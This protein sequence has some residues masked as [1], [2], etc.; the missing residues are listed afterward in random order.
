MLVL[1][2]KNVYILTIYYQLTCLDKN[3]ALIYTIESHLCQC[4]LI[5]MLPCQQCSEII[6]DIK[7]RKGAIIGHISHIFGGFM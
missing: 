1:S 4:S 3:N 2:G 7:D 6:Y 5:C